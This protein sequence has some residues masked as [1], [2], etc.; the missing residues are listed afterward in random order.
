MPEIRNAIDLVNARRMIEGP[1][2]KLRAVSAVK[3]LW[4]VTI[5]DNMLKNNWTP[6]AASMVR[7]RIQFE[8]LSVD[9]QNAYKRSLAFLSNLD[10]IQVDNLAENVSTIVTDPNVREC[11][12]R[13]QFEEVI[14]VKTYSAIVE[15]LFPDNVMEIYDMYHLVPQ[16]GAKNDYIIQSS[17][18]V[19]LDPTPVNKV[20]A[21]VSNIAL[22]G[23]YFFSGFSKFFAIGRST[24]KMQ[25]SIDS[26]KYIQRDELVHLDLFVNIYLTVKRERPELF[27]PSLLE[28][29]QAILRQACDLECAWGEYLGSVPG[30]TTEMN[31]E[32]IQY[33][34]EKRARSIGLQGIFP[35]AKNP[36]EWV[37]GYSVINGSQ[38]NFF[39]SKPMTYSE[40]RPVFR[41]RRRAPDLVETQSLPGPVL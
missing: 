9:Q 33:L 1:S 15:T 38:K 31:T 20:K 32:Y 24:G 34:T 5:W 12:Y 22:E 39:E 11:L 4:A 28:E 19:V 25:G 23:I 30:C 18:E 17:R 21:I 40:D 6:D 13:Q 26:I 14:H 10:S 3:Y 35:N 16:L 37:D 36:I 7:D 2:D 41:S 29:Y 8:E 27:T